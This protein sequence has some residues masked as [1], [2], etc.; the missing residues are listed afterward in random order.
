M[1]N[2]IKSVFAACQASISVHQKLL[3]ALKTIYD[4]AESE[5]AF[6][7]EFV[8]LLRR[9]LMRSEKSPPV[10]RTIEFAARFAK[11]L[12]PVSDETLAED[13]EA[14]EVHPFF[15]RLFEFLVNNHRAA[16]SSVRL[17]CCQL[18]NKLLLHLG[19]N[20]YLDDALCDRAYDAMLERLQDTVPAVRVQAVFALSRL[21]E[22]QNKQCPVIRAYVF[23]LRNDPSAD[24]RRAVLLN[25]GGSAATLPHVLE[26]VRDSSAGVRRQAYTFLTKVHIKSVSMSER[27]RVLKE[28]LQDRDETVR[29]TVQKDLLQFWLR[30]L[31]GSATQLLRCL[32]VEMCPD[33]AEMVVKAM[34][35]ETSYRDMVDS[36][37]LPSETRLFAPEELTPERAILWRVLCDH[38]RAE[39]GGADSQLERIAPDV[40]ALCGLI[41][42]LSAAA[43]ADGESPESQ[44]FVLRQLIQLAAGLELWDEFARRSLAGLV[45]G[46]LRS[47]RLAPQLV[48]PLV[49]LYGHAV[50]D[51]AA[52][53]RALVEAITDIRAP[54]TG[55]APEPEQPAAPAPAEQ[56]ER[57]L[58]R[59]Q[60]RVRLNELRDQLEEAV[61]GRDYAA[62]QELQREQDACLQ[63]EKELQDREEPA[64][65]AETEQAESEGCLERD[66]PVTLAKCLQIVFE[67]L[68]ALPLKKLPAELRALTETLV[69]PAVQSE[70]PGVREVAVRALGAVCLL[71]KQLAE[72]NLVLFV[73]VAH[74]DQCEVQQSALRAVFDQLSVH[75]LEVAA[76][77][78]EPEQMAPLITALT[79]MLDAGEPEVR[80]LVAEGLC[81][82]LIHGR[83]T[84]ARLLERLVLMWYN[85]L[86]DGDGFLRNMLGV[87]FPAFGSSG[88]A[89]QEQLAEAML[90]TIT[91][92]IEAP[93]TSPLVEVDPDDVACFFVQLTQPAML[94]AR[95][96][97]L[98]GSVHETLAYRLLNAL[99][100]GTSSCGTDRVLA[101]AL[102]QLDLSGSADAVLRELRRLAGRA[103]GE[104]DDETDKQT[105]RHLRRF[106]AGL[107]TLL[108]SR[109]TT[110]STPTVT[111]A[112]RRSRP[113][114]AAADVEL[115]TGLDSSQGSP[116]RP[117]AASAVPETPEQAAPDDPTG[118][119]ELFLAASADSE[120]YST[121]LQETADQ[122]ALS[123]G[124]RLATAPAEKR[125][126]ETPP[127]RRP[128]GRLSRRAPAAPK[129]APAATASPATVP[130][131]RSR[132]AASASTAE[133]AAPTRRASN[134][135]RAPP[136]AVRT[137]EDSPEPTIEDSDSGSAVSAT[138]VTGQRAGGRSSA[139]L[140][141]SSD[142]LSAGERTPD[143][144]LSGPVT[145][146]R[147]SARSRVEETPESDIS[148]VSRSTR[149]SR[150]RVEE[151]PD[152]SPSGAALRTKRGSRA[153]PAAPQS[154]DSSVSSAAAPPARS[155]RKA[156]TKNTSPAPVRKT[157]RRASARK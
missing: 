25:I 155:A 66:D 68:Q 56:R 146:A 31:S 125:P 53:L 122:S 43:P 47:E 78:E 126:A 134:V 75:G 152:P 85:P 48:P 140:K 15:R 59:A 76:P 153:R 39:G 65:P 138:V 129:R 145:G 51:A 46:L 36:L 86:M 127:P 23:H 22:P 141:P 124:G 112:P 98:E 144:V 6:F 67:L 72:Q 84:S 58:R 41:Q 120:E 99:I 69:L 118:G 7:A 104:D 49:R 87:F 149:A 128:G 114:G 33:V 157:T 147:R 13:E 116:T 17:R 1:L 88:R 2:S 107:T 137:E 150:T 10:E 11:H 102:P 111:P 94:S 101:R 19:E 90:P 55:T 143:S 131:K 12:S 30:L 73:Q 63:E 117:A 24:V 8:S 54:L 57:R 108:A 82:L 61:A 42:Q 136:P 97:A 100:D 156:A 50:P 21:Q 139:R 83:V 37:G 74:A 77:P 60:L 154:P 18:I 151:S 121:C 103:L 105:A 70:E 148:T 44:W 16:D 91:T 109:P 115:E 133:S 9:S 4:G 35:R 64:P 119:E 26:R 79:G 38:L 32:Y 3:S 96:A 92:V 106:T 142:E 135:R 20:A 130:A 40:P 110:D 95:E 52:R 123:A 80:G 29:R 93:M 132:K 62:A 113:A 5:E 81:K 71:D 27:R 14:E 45:D 28:G 34:C 89:G